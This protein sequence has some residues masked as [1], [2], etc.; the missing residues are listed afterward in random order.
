MIIFSQIKKIGN[1]ETRKRNDRTPIS[2]NYDSV[3]G[4]VGENLNYDELV[5]YKQ[6]AVIP[7]YCV[8]YKI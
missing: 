8:I 7:S 2:S 5:V 6:K 3:F 1:Y 4:D